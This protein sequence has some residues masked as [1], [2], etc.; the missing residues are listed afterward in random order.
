MAGAHV[1][2]LLA[3]ARGLLG[4]WGAPPDGPAWGALACAGLAVLLAAFPENARYVLS[5]IKPRTFAGGCAF[6][7]ALL[8]L[9][10]V[11]FYLRGGPRIVDAT[12]YFLQG[13]A[14]SEGHFAWHVPVPS[15]SFRGRFTLFHDDPARG[16]TVAGIFPPGYPLLL[17]LGFAVGAPLAVGPALAAGVVF[18]TFALAKDL[19]R[20]AGM[21]RAACDSVA[22]VA[23]LLSVVCAALR[24]H[25]ADT[26][27]HGACAL[28]FA[29]ALLAALRARAA[30]LPWVF[31]LAGA[32][33]GFVVSA[34]FAS[35]LALGAVV[36]ALAARS[37]ARGRAL[38]ACALGAV[39]GVLLLLVAQDAATGDAL[40]STQRAYYAASD[41]PPGCFRYGFG[42][43]IGCLLEHG[44]FV[45]ARLMD[46]A[47]AAASS[48]TSHFGLLAALGTTA[49]RLGHHLAD[50]ANLGP[51]ALVALVPARRAPSRGVRASL[52]LV[53]ALVL[54]Y[55]PFYFDGDY[56]GGGARFFAD[57]LP[58]E[59]ALAALGLA[60]LAS[61]LRL[62]RPRVFGAFIAL[63]LTGFAVHMSY[64][65][66]SLRA[67]DGGHPMYEAEALARAHVTSPR[68]ESAPKPTLLLLD[69]DHGFDLAFDPAAWDEGATSAHH[70]A[71]ARLR[72]DDLDRLLYEGLGHPA[73]WVYRFREPEAKTVG[74]LVNRHEAEAVLEPWTP[75]ARTQW[76][77]DAETWRFE[78]E[79]EWPPKWQVNAW[80]EPAWVTDTCASPAGNGRVLAVH[81]S[82]GGGTVAIALPIPHAGAW[83]IEPRVLRGG[84]LE[85]AVGTMELWFQGHHIVWDLSTGAEAPGAPPTC[86]S[87]LTRPLEASGD[88]PAEAQLNINV[89]S[90]TVNLD[91]ILLRPEPNRAR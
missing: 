11:A 18:A 6:L 70:V 89:A 72:G 88:G 33:L 53:A 41:G 42:A 36:V 45:R 57:V 10:Y 22:R 86:P 63:S 7:A 68:T 60:Q 16:P 80:A 28:A 77:G 43:G 55:V 84:E 12:T 90:G 75:G 40:A 37:E 74:D 81:A 69:T 13:R 49:R 32:G 76:S 2:T 56:P 38:V 24:Y 62:T 66:E 65:H 47:G 26:M 52:A 1:L 5:R 44:D 64:A 21:D 31:L 17:S 8:S 82:G 4:P 87:L 83:L 3:F 30:R 34:R 61:S 19:A 51:L 35:S 23:A 58:V 79:N 71:V 67:R 14:L 85:P 15:A 46:G 20:E 50:V 25:T 59:H 91:R 73:S 48:A 39:P 27:A 29:C 9:G 78:S 54:A